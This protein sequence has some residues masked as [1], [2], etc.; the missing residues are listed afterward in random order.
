M[1]VALDPL[2]PQGAT[3]GMPQNALRKSPIDEE[4]EAS[5]KYAIFIGERPIRLKFRISEPMLAKNP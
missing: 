5:F 1:Q 4:Q 2:I 3:T